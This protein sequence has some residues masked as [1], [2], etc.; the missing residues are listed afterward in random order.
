MEINHFVVGELETNSYTVLGRDYALIIDPADKD[1]RLLEF[2]RKTKDKTYKYILLTHGHADHILG[3]N[4]IKEI[5][6]CPIV[7]GKN[8]AEILENPDYNLSPFILGIQVSLLAD[9]LLS[10]GDTINLGE[11]T[12][13][14]LETPGH[15]KGSVCYIINDVMFSGDTF[16]KGTIGRT[17]F[18]TSNVME[19]IKS[20][21]RLSLIKTDYTVYPGHD[22]KTTLF[23]EQKNNQ[24]MRF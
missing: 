23:C 14:V 20:L 22:Q 12:L 3:V 19:M 5:W 7:I 4:A 17:D 24:Y 1:E 10:E 15:T 2:A 6:N 8:E 9:M 21:K 13:K 16:F 18:P 11:D